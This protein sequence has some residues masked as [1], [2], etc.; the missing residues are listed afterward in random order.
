M[1]EN[2]ADAKTFLA[3]IGDL[4][5]K[6]A[7]LEK[8]YDAASLNAEKMKNMHDKIISDISEL[9]SK[10]ESIKAK[11]SVA[12]AQE[13]INKINSTMVGERDSMSAFERMEAKADKMLDEATAMAELNAKLKD[14]A[15]DLTAKYN[16]TESTVDD[17]LAALKAK[18]GK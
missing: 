7:D 9:Q 2:E 5:Q 6:K 17:E 10:R 13:K 14:E 1:A 8:I 3:K 15:E 16:G 12:K 18:L 4:V 11:M